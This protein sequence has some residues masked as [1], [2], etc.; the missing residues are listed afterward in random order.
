M[1]NL[2]VCHCRLCTE[3]GSEVAS[4]MAGW[5]VCWL[6]GR[7]EGARRMHFCARD[8]GEINLNYGYS[9]LIH[10]LALLH[11]LCLARRRVFLFCEFSSVWVNGNI[12][13]IE[14]GG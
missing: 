5:L 1:C 10:R 9:N 6:V 2:F 7:Q 12:F 13:E 3:I 14:R 11:S 4:W 8:K